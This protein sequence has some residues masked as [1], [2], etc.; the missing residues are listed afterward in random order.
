MSRLI[1]LTT[2][3]AVI[4][5]YC[6]TLAEECGASSPEILTLFTHATTNSAV[7]SG[8]CDQHI[9]YM[10]NECDIS[11]CVDEVSNSIVKNNAIDD[12]KSKGGENLEGNWLEAL[13]GFSIVSKSLAKLH[14]ALKKIGNCDAGYEWN[15]GDYREDCDNCMKCV[16]KEM[17][18]D[19]SGSDSDAG[20]GPVTLY[21]RDT[22]LA[23]L[24]QINQALDAGENFMEVPGRV[25]QANGVDSNDSFEYSCKEHKKNKSD[26]EFA[27]AMIAFEKAA[28]AAMGEMMGNVFG[29]MMGGAGAAGPGA[30]AGMPD[31]QGMMAGLMAGMQGG[32]PE[33]G[34]GQGMPDMSA[35]MGMMGGPPGGGG[36]PGGNPMAAMMGAMGGMGGPPQGGGGG[37][38][39]GAMGGMGGMMGAM[40]GMGGGFGGGFG[41]GGD[42]DDEGG[43]DDDFGGDDFGGND[44]FDDDF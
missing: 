10:S 14:L 27:N 13:G 7:I 31:M 12:C 28:E 36:A 21:D 32:A 11:G 23:C 25:C 24:Q 19:A 42:D 1:N 16:T 41:G 26:T 29:G 6:K 39:M 40:G 44:D 3:S 38:P 18:G 15:K 9:P 5:S 2:N 20:S 33:G 30:G 35:M 43:F 22:C 37:N 34:G 17:G 4:S 8:M